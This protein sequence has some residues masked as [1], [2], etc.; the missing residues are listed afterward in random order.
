MPGKHGVWNGATDLKTVSQQD[1]RIRQ[2]IEIPFPAAMVRIRHIHLAGK[3][4]DFPGQQ[5]ASD[6]RA[7][8]AL[9]E[10]TY[11]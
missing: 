7:I 9:T 1:D 11:D 3:T 10:A 4:W 2:H 8:V 5:G 6:A